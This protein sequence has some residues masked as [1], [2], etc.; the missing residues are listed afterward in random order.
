MYTRTDSILGLE[1]IYRTNND[2]EE[3]DY[4]KRVMKELSYFSK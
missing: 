1:I 3:I 4:F 2:E